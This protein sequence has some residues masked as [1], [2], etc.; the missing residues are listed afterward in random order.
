MSSGDYGPGQPAGDPPGSN[1]CLSNLAEGLNGTIFNPSYPSDCPYVTSV[2]ATMLP[3]NG[4][5]NDEELVMNVPSLVPGF[6]S[7]GKRSI[8][9]DQSTLLTRYRQGGFSNFYPMPSYQSKAVTN[10]LDNYVPE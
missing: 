8:T 5:V 10:Y 2:G 1:G 7:S 4:T 9:D 6:S 3:R